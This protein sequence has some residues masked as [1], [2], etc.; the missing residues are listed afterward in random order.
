MKSAADEL[1]LIDQF[2]SDDE[3]TAYI[4][5]GL[6]SS[7]ENIYAAFRTRDTTIRFEELKDK[8]VEHDNY[9]KRIETQSKDSFITAHIA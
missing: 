5:N 3:L 4:L 9:I 8:L 7:F 6:S 1:G 2:V